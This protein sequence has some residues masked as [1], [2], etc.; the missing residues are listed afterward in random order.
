MMSGSGDIPIVVQQIN[1]GTPASRYSAVHIGIASS[2]R[3]VGTIFVKQAKTAR[4]LRHM[5]HE[6][7]FGVCNQV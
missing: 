2:R 7:V 5:G 6:E 3:L 1:L 4:S